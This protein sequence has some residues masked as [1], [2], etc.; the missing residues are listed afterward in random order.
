MADAVL[1]RH[2]GLFVGERI[3]PRPV[4]AEKIGAW[5]AIRM[6]FAFIG[7]SI[8]MAHLKWYSLVIGDVGSAV[9]SRVH[10]LA[11]GPDRAQYAVV[12]NGELEGGTADWRQVGRASAHLDQLLHQS[13]PRPHEVAG[14]FSAVWEDYVNS[15]L[16][17]MDAGDRAPGMPIQVGTERGVL[18]R[19]SDCV[20]APEEAFQVPPRIAAAIGGI[21]DVRAADPLGQ[22]TL[23]ARLRQLSAQPALARD[24]ETVLRDLGN[25]QQQTQHSYAAYT[26]VRL[27]DLLRQTSQEVSRLLQRTADRGR[28]DTSNARGQARQKR[29]AAWMRAILFTFLGL[30]VVLGVLTG[31]G[32]LTWWGA[33]VGAGAGLVI[34]LAGS[35]VLFVQGQRELFH[36]LNR[37]KAEMTQAEADEVN[38]RTAVRDLNRQTEAYGQFLEWTRVLGV[39]LRAPF[40]NAAAR[41]PDSGT[42][43]DGLPANTRV[44]R[45]EVD[46]GA[47]AEVVALMRRELYHYGWLS[48]PW[49]ATLADAGSRLGTG[50][51][52]LTADPRR[53]FAQ[54]ASVRES[55]LAAWADELERSGVG[56]A[57]GEQS[58]HGALQRLSQPDYRSRLVSHVV[59]PGRDGGP[60][61]TLSERDFMAG[62]GEPHRPGR[63]DSG[64]LAREARLEGKDT[65]VQVWPLEYIEGLSRQAVLVELGD[66]L[67]DY[68]FDLGE[69]TGTPGSAATDRSLIPPDPFADRPADPGADRPVAPLPPTSAPDSGWVF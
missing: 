59:V 39:L 9:A 63:F 52:D 51:H 25:W 60:P 57:A 48:G 38:V 7:A 6:L 15:G 10:Q 58:W 17:L 24:A 2:A 26:G 19:M 64:V 43:E 33:L 67:P 4:R 56:T 31:I 23:A 42:I 69:R 22:H 66:G 62:V 55:Y 36:D 16:T 32:I 41:T 40:G 3:Q 12:A 1:T 21:S 28:V 46:P 49:R 8:T 37:R 47:T 18:R 53:M 14:D 27:A 5:Q 68:T 45:A 35:F 44:G 34:W 29:I 50:T 13:G 65:V 11:F 61:T 54:R 20:P 30:A